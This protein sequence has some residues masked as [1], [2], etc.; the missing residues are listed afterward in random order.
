MIYQPSLNGTA[1]SWNNSTKENHLSYVYPEVYLESVATAVEAAKESNLSIRI[2]DQDL[3]EIH[4][5]ALLKMYTKDIETAIYEGKYGLAYKK[6]LD[7]IVSYAAMLRSAQSLTINLTQAFPP[8]L[9]ESFTYE[10]LF[11]DIRTALS[12]RLMNANNGFGFEFI[13]NNDGSFSIHRLSVNGV[14]P[15]NDYPYQNG[16]S[17][18]FPSLDD[19]SSIVNRLFEVIS[20]LTVGDNIVFEF[21]PVDNSILRSIIEEARLLLFKAKFSWPSGFV[22]DYRWEKNK[23][24]VKR[25]TWDGKSSPVEEP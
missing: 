21:P 24:T 4:T 22:Y 17:F 10:Q 16:E 25:L 2:D 12:K 5:K 6:L 20:S 13:C 11:A 23:L 8:E 1:I 14:Y 3:G 7:C 9:L 15:E 19:R 18:T